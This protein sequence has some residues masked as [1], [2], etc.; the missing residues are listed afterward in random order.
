MW[1]LAMA[2][3]VHMALATFHYRYGKLMYQDNGYESC[4]RSL[5][6]HCLLGQYGC[7]TNCCCPQGC[8]GG[9]CAAQYCCFKPELSV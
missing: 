7:F 2:E 4:A 9:C 8:C 3:L 6:C 1:V 5:C